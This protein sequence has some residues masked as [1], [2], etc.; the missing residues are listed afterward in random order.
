M[1]D[2][3][4]KSSS[5]TENMDDWDLLESQTSDLPPKH[6]K[7]QSIHKSTPREDYSDSF[8]EVGLSSEEGDVVN[9]LPDQRFQIIKEGKDPYN[10]LVKQ[11]LGLGLK[12]AETSHVVGCVVDRDKML[13]YLGWLREQDFTKLRIEPRV[14]A[15]EDLNAE[16]LR[17]LSTTEFQN[18]SYRTPTVDG[19]KSK[20]SRRDSGLLKCGKS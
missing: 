4:S 20:R 19:G 14:D 12:P 11:L 5:S 8:S 10:G 9:D 13:H 18:V 6:E 17:Q 16:N 1:R 2:V 7:L 15:N 3:K